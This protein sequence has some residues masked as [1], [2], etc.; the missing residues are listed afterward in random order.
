MTMEAQEIADRLGALLEGQSDVQI[1]RVQPP[2][3]A[4]DGDLAWIADD[5][6]I[7]DGLAASA[8]LVGMNRTADGLADIPAVLR[9]DNSSE[10]FAR[11]ILLIHPEPDPPFEGIDAS[12]IIHPDATVD[13]GCSIGPNVFIGDGVQVGSEALL[14]P[15][16][17]VLGPTRI[18]A[19]VVLHANVVIYAQTTIGE[20]V[21]IHAG[22]I[23]GGDGFGYATSSEGPRKVPHRGG[24]QIGRD[25]EIGC[26]CTIDRG[27]HDDTIIGQ[28]SKLDNLVH[29]AHNVEVGNFCFFA[30]QVGIA[31]SA[32]IGDACEF[33]G[34][35]GMIG[36][37]EVG[38]RT[39]VAAKSAVMRNSDGDQ[40]LMGVPADDARHTRKIFGIIS[41]LP[42]LR[43]RIR[44]LE[45]RLEEMDDRE[46]CP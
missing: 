20:G 42:Q 5:R 10:A 28:G 11:A 39:Q 23:V 2:E 25:V 22:S 32:V 21:T 18:G 4:G 19:G 35:S 1:E 41:Q 31:G 40:I 30:A 36:H 9:H 15:G 14:H 24:V 3:S 37:I 33:G 34:Q 6:P 16:V 27:A 8:V 26:N 7:P 43:D 12:A 13:P 29:I 38:D 45:K 17:V 46:S 44:Q